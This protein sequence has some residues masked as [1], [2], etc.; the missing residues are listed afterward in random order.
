MLQEI[1]SVGTSVR[2]GVFKLRVPFVFSEYLLTK[3]TT[4]RHELPVKNDLSHQNIKDR[5]Y[6]HNDPVAEKLRKLTYP[7]RLL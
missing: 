6:G 4:N 7:L 3:I 1:A 5:Y 2:T